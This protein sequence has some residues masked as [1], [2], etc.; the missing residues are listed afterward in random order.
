MADQHSAQSERQ[1]PYWVC[2]CKTCKRQLRDATSICCG[3]YGRTIYL[4]PAED[5]KKAE[6]RAYEAGFNEGQRGD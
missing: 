1:E 5:V 2:A 6:R 3:D 4:V